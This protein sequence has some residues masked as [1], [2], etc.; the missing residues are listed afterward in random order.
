MKKYISLI[1]ILVISP[2]WCAFAKDIP[3]TDSNDV[4]IPYH[5]GKMWGYVNYKKEIVIPLRYSGAEVFNKYGLAKVCVGDYYSKDLKYGYIDKNG[6]EIIPIGKYYSL[7]NIEDSVL[8]YGVTVHDTVFYGLM[9][10]KGNVLIKP[11]YRQYLIFREGYAIINISDNS[12]HVYSSKDYIVINTKG[13]TITTHKYARI[14]PFVHGYAAVALINDS[15][16]YR[17]GAINTEGKEIIPL[18]YNEMKC[19]FSNIYIDSNSFNK[20]LIAVKKGAPFSPNW[21][22]ININGE[23][24]IDFKYDFISN[25]IGDCFIIGERT[26][27]NSY[28]QEPDKY[29]IININGET[30]TPI[31]YKELRAFNNDLFIAKY[32]DKFGIINSKNEIISSFKYDMINNLGNG[33]A[34][35]GINKNGNWKGRNWGIIDS[36][37]EVVIKPGFDYIHNLH[38]GYFQV[39]ID[40]KSGLF[41]YTGKQVLPIIYTECW[42][43][44]DGEYFIVMN[45]SMMMGIVNAKNETIIPFKYNFIFQEPML[46]K[47]IF[48]IIKLETSFQRNQHFRLFEFID[49]NM[50]EY[51][52]N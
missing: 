29:G 39:E 22:V 41:D 40:K 6:I 12:L 35:I 19:E 9:D 5:K 4:L 1:F 15:N 10:L 47:G 38:N 44:S 30:I 8:N 42:G 7:G 37:G 31:I 17:Y 3:T 32:E 49:N 24:V 34:E 36:K 33:F 28:Y 50:V 26:Y 18:I 21:G 45:D 20:G 14:S 13:D 51:F 16:Q 25:C 46:G 48:G 27:H 2:G 11:V 23:T 52:D 43:S